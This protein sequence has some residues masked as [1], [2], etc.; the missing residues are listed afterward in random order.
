MTRLLAR[1]CFAGSRQGAQ[2]MRLFVGDEARLD[3]AVRGE[4]GD[5]HRV[6]HVGLAPGNGFDVSRVGKHKLELALA[7][8]L[9]LKAA[10]KRRSPPSPPRCTGSSST[11]PAGPQDSVVVAKV[12]QSR[13]AFIPDIA[14]THANRA[15]LVNVQSGDAIMH[16]VHHRLLID[17]RGPR[18]LYQ[19]KS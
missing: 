2:T 13:V 15:V 6:V 17:C 19:Y 12:R 4:I 18:A 7:Q 14:R 11:I 1:Q 8:Y 5:P 3:Q 16:H 9:E 10:N